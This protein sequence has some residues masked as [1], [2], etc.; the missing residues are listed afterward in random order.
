MRD[1]PID[2]QF[3][4]KLRLDSEG[5]SGRSATVELTL[6]EF[7]A[8]ADKAIDLSR[9]PLSSDRAAWTHPSDDSATQ[10]LAE[11]ARHAGITT[12]RYQSVRDP[13]GFCWPC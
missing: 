12:I 9:P 11:Q 2:S 10:A 13:D 6:F 8:A 3:S 1:T 4:H 5:L 7:A